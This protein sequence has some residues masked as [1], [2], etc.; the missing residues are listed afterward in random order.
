[1]R[2]CLHRV[3]SG[4]STVDQVAEGDI[5]PLDRGAAGKVLLAFDGEKGD[6]FDEIRRRCSAISRGERDA[7]CGAV[8]APVFG[9]RGRILGAL[10]ISGPLSRFTPERTEWQLE[11][12]VTAAAAL[13]S[14]LGGD[15]SRFPAR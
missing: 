15:A 13:T 3:Q 14:A 7:D 12:V 6:A 8:S 11:Q 5:L 9:A 1:M 4:H 2:I 10:S